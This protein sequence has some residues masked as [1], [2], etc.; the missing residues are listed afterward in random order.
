[1][2]RHTLI[3]QHWTIRAGDWDSCAQRGTHKTFVYFRFVLFFGFRQ[4][5]MTITNRGKICIIVEVYFIL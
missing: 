3:S 1:M 4:G 5:K 2:K